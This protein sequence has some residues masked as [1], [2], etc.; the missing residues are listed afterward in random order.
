[1][2][3]AIGTLYLVAT[4]IGNLEDITLR[5]LRVLREVHLIAAEDTRH[6]RKLLQHYEIPTPSTAYHEHNKLARLPAMLAALEQ[7]D[8]A[9]V[10]DAG[11]PGINDPGAELVAAA[12]EAGFPVVPIPGPSAPIAALIGSGLPTDQWVYLGFLPSRPA[13]RR[14]SLETWRDVEATLVCLE[15]PHRLLAALRDLQTVLGNRRI[16]IARELTKLHEEWIRGSISDAIQRFEAVAPRGEITMVIAGASAEDTATDAG[17]PM[18][19]WQTEAKRRLVALRAEGISGSA[20]A[21]EVARD[22]RAPRGL[23][24]KLWTELDADD[25]S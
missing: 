11:T 20:A 1:L 24:Y 15:A 8:V 14:R 5:A 22:L 10:S 25:S 23:V 16:A 4:P 6:T 7:G 12:I 19:D 18:A 21:K 13:E 3:A 9:L 2:E 17:E